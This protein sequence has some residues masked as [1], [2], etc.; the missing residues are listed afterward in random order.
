VV[1]RKIYT[2]EISPHFS[3]T[4]IPIELMTRDQSTNRTPNLDYELIFDGGSRGNPG[5]A[6]GSYQIR[7]SRGEDRKP[8]RL[9]LGE[10]TNNEAEYRTLIRAF[11][12]LLNEFDQDG[13]DPGAVRLKVYGDSQ[14]VIRQ[15]Q[16]QWKA[17]DA[18]MRDLRDQ[19]LRLG[20]PL[21]SVEF[22]HQARWRSVAALGH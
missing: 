6:Y 19:V 12:D 13:I 3:T 7:H 8:V 14:L 18:R 4:G 21:G 9:H 2:S 22:V 17:K 5:L 1:Y 16:G 20:N 15:L 11:E 10:G